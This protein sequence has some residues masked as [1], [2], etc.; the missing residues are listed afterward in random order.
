MEEMKN[1][2]VTII[3]AVSGGSLEC[4]RNNNDIVQELVSY[5]IVI[6]S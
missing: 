6:G 2:T 5:D 4:A 1:K 3:I